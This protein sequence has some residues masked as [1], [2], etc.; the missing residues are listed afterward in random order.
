[1]GTNRGPPTVWIH[2]FLISLSSHTLKVHNWGTVSSA[3]GSLFLVSVL[4]HRPAAA[5]GF[6]GQRERKGEKPRLHTTE[7]NCP[8]KSSVAG[9][10]SDRVSTEGSR[11]TGFRGLHSAPGGL[12]QSPA[13]ITGRTPWMECQSVAG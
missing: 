12:Q 13:S 8:R 4:H 11:A 3:G 9:R 5:F 2:L 1:M 7:N 10:G 6:P